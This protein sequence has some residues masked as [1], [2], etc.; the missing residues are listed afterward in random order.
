[1]YLFTG[2]INCLNC[3]GKYRGKKM[4]DRKAYICSTHSK[5]SAHCRRYVIQEEYL[6]HVIKK[7]LEINKIEGNDIINCVKKIEVKDRGFIIYYKDG[8]PNSIID[9]NE[10]Y[11]TKLHF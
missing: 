5:D 1:M 6:I 9:E 3:S 10:G 4:R 2:I 8:S 7:H 11:G